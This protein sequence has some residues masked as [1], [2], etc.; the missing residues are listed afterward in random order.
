MTQLP[1]SQLSA[2]RERFSRQGSVYLR[3]GAAPRT[4]IQ[5]SLPRNHEDTKSM[6]LTTMTIAMMA[7]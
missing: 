2:A 5:T 1:A 6:M 4:T 7:R 3:L